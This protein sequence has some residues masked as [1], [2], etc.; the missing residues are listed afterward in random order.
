VG[1]SVVVVDR[2]VV[3][4]WLEVSGDKVDDVVPEGGGSVS[5]PPGGTLSVWVQEDASNTT[6]LNT[7]PLNTTLESPS[8]ILIKA[9][10]A[11]PGKL[12]GS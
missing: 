7:T 10:F 2:T 12:L 4:G 3:G 9:E 11:R 5:A 1:G 8:R 6:P